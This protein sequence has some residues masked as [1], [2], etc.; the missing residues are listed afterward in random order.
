[1]AAPP[2]TDESVAAWAVRTAAS[3]VRLA[4]PMMARTITRAAACVAWSAAATGLV[5]GC[6]T[7]DLL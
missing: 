2:L 3:V 1:L 5:S 4:S 7:W 6:S